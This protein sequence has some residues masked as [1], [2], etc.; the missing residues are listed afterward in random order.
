M[1]FGRREAFNSVNIVLCGQGKVKFFK[2]EHE[3]DSG[4]SRPGSRMRMEMS[5]KKCKYLSRI[6]IF[7]ST[8]MKI[9]DKIQFDLVIPKYSE[10][11][12]HV[13]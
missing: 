13:N 3:H 11:L 2:Q 9:W 5:W 12:C 1:R 4:T 6:F 7:G 10:N 8:T